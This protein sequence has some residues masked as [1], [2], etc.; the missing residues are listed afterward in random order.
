MSELN[1]NEALVEENT[2][3]EESPAAENS[4]SQNVESGQNTEE[5]LNYL[6]IERA[7][8][9][10]ERVAL[11]N[12][13]KELERKKEEN[14]SAHL[15]KVSTFFWLHYLFNIPFFGFIATIIFSFVG[16]N[17]TRKNYARARMIWHLISILAVLLLVLAILLIIKFFGSDIKEF[18]SEIL[19]KPEGGIS[20][21]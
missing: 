6:K 13:Q 15:T 16:A 17:I 11:T 4:E 9:D 10:R 8:L 18:V 1:E 14:T 12:A 5:V 3:V 7:L 21:T 20:G 19:D 2:V